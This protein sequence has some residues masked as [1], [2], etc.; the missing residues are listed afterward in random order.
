[1]KFDF[2]GKSLL[3]TCCREFDLREPDTCKSDRPTNVLINL[4]EHVGSQ[5][6]VKCLSI[7]PLRPE[8][9][10]VGANDPYVRLYDRR[11]LHRRSITF[12]A[13]APARY[14]DFAVLT[15]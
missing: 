15:M 7:N 13:D 14:K 4:S 11:M 12:S 10:A 2:F 9:L 3:V 6:E 8:L 1:M 5:A